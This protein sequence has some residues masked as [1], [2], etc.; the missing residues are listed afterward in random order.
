M[1]A[2]AGED[3]S[4]ARIASGPDSGTVAGTDGTVVVWGNDFQGQTIVPASVVDAVG[5]AAGGNSVGAVLR[6]G[7]VR[8]WGD[9]STGQRTVPA[10]LADVKQLA[11]GTTLCCSQSAI[12][13]IVRYAVSIAI[14]SGDDIH[15]LA[16]IGLQ[17]CPNRKCF[18]NLKRSKK[19]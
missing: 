10:D 5:I 6:D 8:M 1:Y 3:G 4:C 19:I 17:R 16:R 12:G 13:A 7:T 18:S 9:T 15:R 2:I 14:E 11:I